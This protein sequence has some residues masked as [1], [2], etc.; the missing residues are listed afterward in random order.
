MSSVELDLD[1][2]HSTALNDAVIPGRTRIQ[3]NLPQL[4]PRTPVSSIN[5]DPVFDEHD[6]AE[7]LG[8]K[9]D[10]LKKWR[11]RNEGPS[12]IQNG[13]SGPV[14]YVLSV[15]KQLRTEHTDVS[16]QKRPRLD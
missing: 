4:E 13:A 7:I 6:A 8:V 12:Y 10:I 2:N 9:P 14:R 5:D 11:H 15:L 16:P 3:E 1:F